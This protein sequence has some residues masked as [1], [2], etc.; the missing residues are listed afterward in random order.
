MTDRRS[1]ERRIAVLPDLGLCWL[2]SPVP[3]LF[4]VLAILGCHPFEDSSSKGDS[5][6]SPVPPGPAA[7][8][9]GEA[10]NPAD[11]LCDQGTACCTECCEGDNTPVCTTTINEACPLP[12][13][14]ADPPRLQDGLVEEWA[15][16]DADNCAIIEGCV[17][18]SGWRRLLE[19][20]LTTP[21]TGT[22]D[23]KFGDP[24][25]NPLF[26]YSECHDHFHF[27]GYARYSLLDGVTEVAKGHK[28]AFCLLDFEAW[29]EDA[30]PRP[31]YTC[32]RQGISAGWAD[33]YGGH[34]DC[35][36]IDITD[37]PAGSYTVH[38]TVNVDSIIPELDYENNV[39]DA[40]WT[41]VDPVDLPAVTDPCD[42]PAGRI[43]VGQGEVRDCGWSVA[44]NY[45]CAPGEPVDAS[46][47]GGCADSCVGDPVMRVCE[48]ADNP[49]YS[50]QALGSDDDS[51]GTSACPVVSVT[52]PAGGVVTVLTASWKSSIGPATC[53]PLVE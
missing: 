46:C 53:D 10:C 50:F 44:G 39:A 45:T 1:P 21:N 13:L 47:S 28:Q 18:A 9:L 29:T 36:W 2:D 33:T 41:V 7:L 49:C 23:V 22:A 3:C 5:G 35:Q 27:D 25:N 42:P 52:C 38:A 17:L 24:S 43:D 6:S 11:D 31:L 51:C 32:E 15:Y 16:F 12:D 14:S 48:G 30:R 19:F 8:T 37:V 40:T 34:L 20:D 26:H 4:V